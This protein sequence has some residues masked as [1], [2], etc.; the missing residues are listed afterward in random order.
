MCLSFWEFEKEQI[1]EDIESLEYLFSHNFY[2]LP[3]LEC[4]ITAEGI[5]SISNYL[6]QDGIVLEELNLSENSGFF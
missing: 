2:Y 3:L 5:K 4:G 1:I 6:S